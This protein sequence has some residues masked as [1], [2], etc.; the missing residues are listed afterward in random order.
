[1]SC[2]KV[3]TPGPAPKRYTAIRIDATTGETVW[4][5]RWKR[6]YSD[7]G[8]AAQ[9]YVTP[10]GS[11]VDG[12][13]VYW[14]SFI[15]GETPAGVLNLWRK[16]HAD[17][18]ATTSEG[19]TDVDPPDMD[20]RGKLARWQGIDR[21]TYSGAYIGLASIFGFD[22]IARLTTDAE[23]IDWYVNDG[24]LTTDPD[25]FPTPEGILVGGY[26]IDDE[27]YLAWADPY[28]KAHHPAGILNPGGEDDATPLRA[29]L[30]NDGAVVWSRIDEYDNFNPR[31]GTDL[32]DQIDD[33][34]AGG[35]V[36][37][38]GSEYLVG[39]DAETWEFRCNAGMRIS[40]DL[41]VS[42]WNCLAYL[43]NPE[44]EGNEPTWLEIL[45]AHDVD[46]GEI[47]AS[48]LF[49]R[50]D[51]FASEPLYQFNQDAGGWFGEMNPLVTGGWTLIDSET[52]GVYGA[53]RYDRGAMDCAPEG[54]GGDD[55]TALLGVCYCE[56]NADLTC[57]TIVCTP[58]GW[59]ARVIVFDGE[60]AGYLLGGNTI[61]RFDAGVITWGRN[62]GGWNRWDN[63]YLLHSSG[64]IIVT[65]SS[66]GG[67]GLYRLDAA[68][69]DTVWQSNA[70]CSSLRIDGDD[71]YAVGS[72]SGTPFP[73]DPP[74]E[75]PPIDYEECVSIDDDGYPYTGVAECL[76][77]T[78]TGAT[79]NERLEHHTADTGQTWGPEAWPCEGSAFVGPNLVTCPDGW[80]L[81][82]ARLVTSN[83]DAEQIVVECSEVLKQAGILFRSESSIGNGNRPTTWAASLEQREYDDD[84]MVRLYDVAPW[85]RESPSEP[86]TRVYPDPVAEAEIPTLGGTLT[87]MVHDDGEN[88]GID[89]DGVRYITYASTAD[90]DRQRI[91]L[92]ST[93]SGVFDNL[94]ACGRS[95][96]EGDDEW[97]WDDAEQ[98]WADMTGEC[99]APC[100]SL[101]P[102]QDG[103]V[104]DETLPGR[105][106]MW[107]V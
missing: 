38:C 44:T 107:Q 62:G 43:Y 90:A 49:L 1:M 18:A 54:A 51:E 17:T 64:D 46:T 79:D 81:H 73:Q 32:Q 59:V 50:P 80:L 9:I 24:V 23:S 27:R 87:L 70:R 68:T 2:C 91:G 39:T 25:P 22:S 5:Q 41:M 105:C 76:E 34:F 56:I 42:H 106:G 103:T 15:S 96:C 21:W 4:V 53:Y 60:A 3:S 86:G 31:V 19:E 67:A 29:V 7:P 99:P 89:V 58:C 52:A 28:Q 45:S 66:D 88:I 71:I 12:E 78:F 14:R 102:I 65:G 84:P 48:K 74:D 63:T 69:G 104:P 100:S 11:F 47:T 98:E 8:A 6:G 40:G 16:L 30:W 20:G 92:F 37:L 72:F 83:V 77:D 55:I 94:Y 13:F 33:H 85:P 95:D 26:T 57:T 75:L 93:G 36:T 101:P 61:E 82:F 10:Y 35:S 97:T